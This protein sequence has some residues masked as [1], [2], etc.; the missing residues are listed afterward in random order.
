MSGC[1]GALMKPNWSASGRVIPVGSFAGTG[2]SASTA[3][4]MSAAERT[5]GYLG[6][7]VKEKRQLGMFPQLFPNMERLIDEE[8]RGHIREEGN[9]SHF[10]FNQE[11]QN[12]GKP[13]WEHLDDDLHVLI[14]CED[15]PNRVYMKLKIGVEQIKKLLV[16]T[17][18]GLDDL[19]RKQLIKL[20]IMNG[21]YRP[22]KQQMRIRLSLNAA[23][24]SLLMGN[25]DCQL[26][27]SPVETA[28]SLVS[29]ALPNSLQSYLVDSAAITPPTLTCSVPR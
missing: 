7:V 22:I 17:Q 28:P 8:R 4:G 10:Y 21:T 13:N 19:K 9:A 29:A 16:P 6:D 2:W 15:T 26:Q 20:A 1:Q 14:Q 12:R 25:G 27:T 23:L 5:M 24:A 3:E 11:E 18:E